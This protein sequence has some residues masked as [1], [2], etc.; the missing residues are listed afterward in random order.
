MLEN[1]KNGY[2]VP[3][4]DIQ[5]LAEIITYIANNKQEAIEIA[6]KARDCA[7]KNFDIKKNII[8]LE[9]IYDNL[10]IN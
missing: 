4:K 5:K 2:I 9:K 1:K 6:K 7:S 8:G 3:I 10:D